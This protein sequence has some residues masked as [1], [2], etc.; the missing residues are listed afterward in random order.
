MLYK[1]IFGMSDAQGTGND[2]SAYQ[3]GRLKLIANAKAFVENVQVVSHDM[4]REAVLSSLVEQRDHF[5]GF[6]GASI[7]QSSLRTNEIFTIFMKI[8]TDPA[9]R[10]VQHLRIYS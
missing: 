5:I 8:I 6:M 9:V 7:T 10:V 2:G 1:P 4:H 3:S